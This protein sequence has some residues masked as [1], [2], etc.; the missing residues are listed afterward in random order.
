[1]NHYKKLFAISLLALSMHQ[2]LLSGQFFDQSLQVV[3]PQ[4]ELQDSQFPQH[5]TDQYF[6]TAVNTE[7]PAE[8]QVLLASA[9]VSDKIVGNYFNNGKTRTLITQE[10]KDGKIITTTE[11]W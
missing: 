7:Q 4:I 2:I 6:Y 9:V 1:M 8:Q 11:T 5:S 3:Q 10:T